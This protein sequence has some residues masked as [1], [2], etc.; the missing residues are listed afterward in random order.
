MNV[1]FKG[2]NLK[3]KNVDWDNV[4]ENA[5]YILNNAWDPGTVGQIRWIGDKWLEDIHES[6]FECADKGSAGCWIANELSKNKNYQIYILKSFGI[7]NLSNTKDVLVQLDV[8][9]E[10]LPSFQFFFEHNDARVVCLQ[11]SDTP[12]SHILTH[13]FL[14][15]SWI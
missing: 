11:F 4:Q 1:E 5:Y 13:Y 10:N 12:D 6:W 2:L 3:I 14:L 15:R 7:M 9:L 8:L